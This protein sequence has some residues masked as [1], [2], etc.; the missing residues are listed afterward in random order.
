MGLHT[1]RAVVS[2]SMRISNSS[3]LVSL[4][5]EKHGLVKV[6]ARGARRPTSRYGAAL[7]PVTLVDAIYYAKEGR[8]IQTISS[9]DIIESYPRIKSSLRVLCVAAAM[10]GA[11]QSVTPPDDPLSGTFAVIA[12]ALDGLER[13]PGSDPEKHLWRFMLRLLAAVGYCPILDRCAVCGKKPK[14]SSV[15]FSYG[16]GGLVCSC[17]EQEGKYGF[18]ISPGALMVM[19]SLMTAR[20]EDL[21]R[22]HI[23]RRQR[24]EIEQ[25]VLQF[26][27]YHTGSSRPPHAF[28]FMKKLDAFEH[29]EEK[30]EPEGHGKHTIDD[31]V[32]E[33]FDQ[34]LTN[35][36]PRG[37]G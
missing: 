13:N 37:I 27:S 11:A 9:A 34:P 28:A 6:M 21:P 17:S 31:L 30:S 5:T 15:F 4:I 33:V 25:A 2:N 26:F 18:R 3:K 20:E 36:N 8:E 16:D 12:D 7:E 22:I 14:T 23:G 10:T 32:H 29:A 35:R 19:K 24:R 1:T